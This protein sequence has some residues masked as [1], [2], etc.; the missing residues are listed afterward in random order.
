MKAITK[1]LSLGTMFALLLMVTGCEKSE[2]DLITAHP[3]KWNK[4]TADSDDEGVQAGIAF[5][6]ALMTGSVWTFYTDGT[7]KVTST[8]SSTPSEGTW[9]LVAKSKIKLVTGSDVDNM[10]IIKLTKNE[11]V[12][13]AKKFNEELNKTITTTIYLKK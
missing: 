5:V 9:E 4:I 6:N 3:W 7:Y 11:L 12:V 1:I 10:T 8:L 2:E 13:E